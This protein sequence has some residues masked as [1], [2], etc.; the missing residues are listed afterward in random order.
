[1]ASSFVRLV[2]QKHL[3]AFS[4]IVV[5]LMSLTGFFCDYLAP[6]SY[7]EI[8]LRDSLAPPSTQHILGTDDLGRDLLSRVIY[9]A[10]SA[11][12]IGL[13]ASALGVVIAILIGLPSGFYGGRLDMIVQRFVDAWM[14]FP[15]LFIILT[16]MTLVGQGLAQMIFVL[17]LSEGIRASRI[18]RSAVISVKENLYVQAA[19]AVGSSTM[20]ILTTHILPNV[21]APII[22]IYT[23]SVGHVILMEATISFLGFGVPP[24]FPSWGGMLSGSGR[25]YMLQAP[26][27]AFWPGLALSAVVFSINMLGDG[28]RDILDP[29]LTGGTMRYDRKT[30]S[31][32]SS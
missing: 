17:G 13:S 12:I 4:G 10:R 25:Q 8:N 28:V 7:V 31:K 32:Q 30:K 21:A 19:V 27:L 20:R 24:P 14:T 3:A 15:G 1:M 29:R 5:V 2:R 23:V 18:M 22:I 9:G 16:L 26:W 6:Y 11:M